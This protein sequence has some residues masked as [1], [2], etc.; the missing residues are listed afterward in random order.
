MLSGEGIQIANLTLKPCGTVFCLSTFVI[1]VVGKG[2]NVV[3]E[4][5]RIT[6][7]PMPAFCK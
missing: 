3:R 4:F 6:L 7:S 2:C 5:L 1:G